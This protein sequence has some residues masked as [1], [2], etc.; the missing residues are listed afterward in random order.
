MFRL[1]RGWDLETL[2]DGDKIFNCFVGI[3]ED[4]KIKKRWLRKEEFLIPFNVT[5]KYAMFYDSLKLI[6]AN[7]GKLI[8]TAAH[9]LRDQPFHVPETK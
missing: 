8:K 7:D 4:E 3:D 5:I 9:N 2:D 1:L 6:A